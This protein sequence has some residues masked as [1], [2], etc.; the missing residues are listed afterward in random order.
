V[1]AP[2]SG[3]PAEDFSIDFYR[4]ERIGKYE[5]VTQLSVGGMAELFL[6]FTSGPGGFRKYVV[7]KRILPDVIWGRR[8]TA[9]TWPWNSS[10]GRT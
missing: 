8:T 4:G 3:A 7:I 5:V 6:G 10:P 2:G 9:S 1:R